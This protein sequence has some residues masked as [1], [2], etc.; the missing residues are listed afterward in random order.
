[1]SKAR[2]SHQRRSIKKGVLKNFTKLTGKY[3]CQSP[4][5]KTTLAQVFSCTFC[6]IVKNTFF[7]E[8]LWTTAFEKL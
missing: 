7:K 8:H 6:E 4:F 3:L 1:M 2:S 5:L